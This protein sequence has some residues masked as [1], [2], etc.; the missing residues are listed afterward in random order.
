MD[1]YIDLLVSRGLISP[2]Q[3][4]DENRIERLDSDSRAAVAALCAQRILETTLLNDHKVGSTFKQ[5]WVRGLELVWRL[6]EGL[7][8]PDDRSVLMVSL[9]RVAS[10]EEE[11][12]SDHTRSTMLD[13]ADEDIPASAIAAA[14]ALVTSEPRYLR[15]NIERYLDW[16][17]SRVERLDRDTIALRKDYY[18]GVIR[19]S[20]Y[21]AKQFAHP[22]AQND[23]RLVENAL[24]LLDREPWTTSMGQSMRESAKVQPESS[25]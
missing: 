8:S 16:T 1:A 22:V 5:E 3:V 14:R 4:K 11:F 18:S 7:S 17:L 10:A 15:L 6:L 12:R 24:S 13:E 23:L 9:D 21:Q 2:R 20:E 25:L 19:L